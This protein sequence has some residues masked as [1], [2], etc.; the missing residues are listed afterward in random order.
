MLPVSIADVGGEPLVSLLCGIGYTA[1][2]GLNPYPYEQIGRRILLLRNA[3]S[4]HHKKILGRV[5]VRL[6]ILR[7]EMHLRKTGPIK[8][9]IDNSALGHGITHETVNR[10]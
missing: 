2:M 8:V 5:Y 1:F 4:F 7:A 9:L 10:R 3:I 6:S